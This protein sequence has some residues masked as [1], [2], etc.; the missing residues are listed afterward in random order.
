M[1]GKNKASD[2]QHQSA[3]RKSVFGSAKRSVMMSKMTPFTTV[4]RRH[5]MTAQRVARRKSQIKQQ[6]EK[7]DTTLNDIVNKTWHVFCCSP[8]HKFN[9]NPKSLQQ[10]SRLLSSVLAVETSRVGGIA[11]SEEI[12]TKAIFSIAQGIAIT[13]DDQPAIKITVNTKDRNNVAEMLLCSLASGD[14]IGDASNNSCTDLKE[15]FTV[16]PLILYKGNQSTKNVMFNWLK[17]EFDCIITK[18][19]FNSLSL[20]W[21]LGM[22]SCMTDSE[23]ACK[24]ISITWKIPIQHTGLDC[25]ESKFEPSSIETLWNACHK[26]SD[27]IV[28]VE[29]VQSLINGLQEHLLRHFCIKFQALPLQQVCFTIANI[30]ADGKIKIL[31]PEHVHTVLC[32]MNNLALE[33]LD[34]RVEKSDEQSM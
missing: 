32:H 1:S 31:S 30:H 19:T 7:V 33:L 11:T 10:L 17:T 3:S 34:W 24:P 18:V 29:E 16:L 21:M 23:E 15:K 9:S 22:W 13:E 14:L 25:I 27:D 12:G 2:P 6:P 4:R 26:G 8:L 28:L 20:A 5:V